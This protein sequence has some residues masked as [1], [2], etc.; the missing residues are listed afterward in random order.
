MSRDKNYRKIIKSTIEKFLSL[1]SDENMLSEEII[2]SRRE[3]SA[4]IKDT[5]K[6]NVVISKKVEYYCVAIVD[7]VNSTN[8]TSRLSFEKT[9]LYYGLF[10]NTMAILS[11]E[12]GAFVIK[13]VGDGLLVYFP[14][15]GNDKDKSAFR[16]VLECGMT[17]IEAREIINDMASEKMLPDINFRISADYGGVMM[18]DSTTSHITDIFGTPVNICNRI[19]SFALPNEMVIG[20]DMYQCVKNENGFVFEEI[21]SCD[22]GQKHPYS[23]YNVKRKIPR[24]LS[25]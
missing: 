17:M 18:A 15:T 25:F 7:L 13:N 3:L 20:G 14:K 2:F 5:A 23:V 19:N 22:V 21:K 8:I 1:S 9:R 16:E 24:K 4:K 11:K 6:F 12:M 10:L